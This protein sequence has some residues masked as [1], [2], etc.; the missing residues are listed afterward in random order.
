MIIK[1]SCKENKLLKTVFCNNLRL[2]NF[3]YSKEN[4]EI[5]CRDLLLSDH[6][7]VSRYKIKKKGAK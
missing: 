6:P 1:T 5:I 7:I 2:E 3:E 4:D